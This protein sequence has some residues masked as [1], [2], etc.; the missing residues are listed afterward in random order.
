MP[1]PAV[2]VASDVIV[3]GA[4]VAGLAA[5]RS[6][7]EAGELMVTLLEARD[8][9]GGRILTLRDPAIDLPIENSALNLCMANRRSY[10]G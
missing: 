7:A 4:G 8:R 10:G 9:I 2:E 3:I 5:A 1:N 6:L